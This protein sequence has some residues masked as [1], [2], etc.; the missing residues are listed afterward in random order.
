MD[1]SLQECGYS[2]NFKRRSETDWLKVRLT[3]RV[4]TEYQHLP[5]DPRTSYE[6]AK[7]ALK[8]RFEPSSRKPRYQ[9]EFHS[10]KKRRTE[11]WAN[12]VQYLRIL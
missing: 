4:Q 2:K 12:Y 11:A 7:E 8:K 5:L 9:A 3:G 10:R 1:L 6:G